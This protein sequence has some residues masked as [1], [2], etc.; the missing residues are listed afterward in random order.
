MKKEYSIP[1]LAILFICSVFVVASLINNNSIPENNLGASINYGSD[2]CIST[3]GD[4]EG[5]K[6]PLGELELIQCEHNV[7]YDTG[8]EAIEDYLADGSGGSDAF[9]WIELCNATAGCGTPQADKSEAYT[10]FA[11]AGLSEVAGTVGDNGNGN[12]SVAHTFTATEDDL[13]TNVTRLR[14]D[15]GDD[16]AGNFFTL[17]NLQTDD[18]L[19]VNW[20]VWVS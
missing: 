9:D 13:L 10:A 4:F 5:R 1:I 12:W 2:V 20:T 16:L 6:T 8:A 11:S 7:L 3:T 18:Q 19:L 15:D 17:V 14:N